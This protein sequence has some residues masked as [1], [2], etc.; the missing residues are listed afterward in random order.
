VS[1]SPVP[2]HAASRAPRGRA[3]D[4]VPGRRRPGRVRPVGADPV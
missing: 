1:P 4:A 3:G 2:G